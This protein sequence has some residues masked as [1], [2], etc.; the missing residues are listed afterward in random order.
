MSE[1]NRYGGA[2]T[3]EQFCFFETRT[4]AR[5]FCDGKTEKE[6]IDAVVTDNL[7]QYPTERTLVSIAKA[8]YKR[9]AGLDDPSL[10]EVVAS[11]SLEEAKQICLYAMMKQYPLVWDFMVRVIGEKYRVFDMSFD[12]MDMNTFFMRLKDSNE[13]VAGWSDSTIEKIKAVLRKLLVEN[14]YLDGLKS[15]HLNP[16]YLESRLENCIRANGDE[17][18]LPAFNCLN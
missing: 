5:L 2:L 10:V 9:M 18:A 4:V 6:A 15:D 7:F 17:E 16:V 13:E 14:E 8:C 1:K 12:T 11:G 3:R